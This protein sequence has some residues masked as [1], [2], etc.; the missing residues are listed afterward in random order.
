[1][2]PSHFTGRPWHSRSSPLARAACATYALLLLYAGLAP[3][4]GW[5]DLGL[6]PFAYLSAPIPAHVTNFDLVVNV[7]AYLPF[8]A[9][10]VFALHPAKRGLTAVLIALV[11]R[12]IARRL[13]RDGAKFPADA[14]SVQP[15]SIDQHGG[16][17][18]GSADRGAFRFKS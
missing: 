15:R 17:C 11:A 7:L 4:S 18:V 16:R 5:R 3:W 12:A 8:G 14:D 2:T 13:Y 9:L 1:M 6:N 10:L